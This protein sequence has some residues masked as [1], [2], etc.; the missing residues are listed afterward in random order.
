MSDTP[1]C[2]VCQTVTARYIQKDTFKHY[3]CPV[4]GLLFVHPAPSTHFLATQVYGEKGKYQGNRVSLPPKPHVGLKEKKIFDFLKKN[5]SKGALLLD[6]GASSG[7]F[8]RLARDNGFMGTGVELNPRTAKLAES[9]GF[10]V[11]VGTLEE[12][13]FSENSFD[14][15][16]AGDVIEHVPDPQVFVQLCFRLLKPGGALLI[17]TPN[18]DCFWARATKKFTE[19]FG[20]PW[21]VLTPPHHLFLFSVKNLDMLAAQEGLVK[22]WFAFGRSP[23]LRY[24]LG[25]LHL[26][27]AYK[28]EK[29]LGTLACMIGAFFLYSLTYFIDLLVTPLKSKDFSYS[30]AYT[31]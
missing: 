17:T 2:I 1:R 18:S 11:F 14:V 13:S 12:A 19:W 4:C 31:K 8:L 7:N 29:R 9:A 20:F 3:E 23:S 28:K 16:H 15:I 5:T 25:A 26:W 6:V 27:G 10:S 21:A 24:S 22:E 30:V